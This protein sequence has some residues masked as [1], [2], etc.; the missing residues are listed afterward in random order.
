MQNMWPDFQ[1]GLGTVLVPV[2]IYT[3]PAQLVRQVRFWQYH[4][5]GRLTISRRGRGE[6]HP[7][8]AAQLM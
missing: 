6:W 4:F 8:G 7:R 2:F 3:G 5:F 1:K